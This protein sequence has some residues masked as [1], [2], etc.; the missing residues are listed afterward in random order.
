VI[1]FHRQNAG[2]VEAGIAKNGGGSPIITLYTCNGFEASIAPSK[3][4]TVK[5]FPIHRG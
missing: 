4:G 1:E 5:P 3:L 2:R